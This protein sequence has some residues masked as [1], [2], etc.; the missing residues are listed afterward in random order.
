MSLS[1]GGIGAARNLAA[2]R[3]LAITHVV[4]ASPIVPCFHAGCLRYRTVAVFDDAGEDI[5]QFFDATNRWIDKVQNST[6]CSLEIKLLSKN[7]YK[8]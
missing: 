5:A 1:A 3:G 6:N 4:N 7:I 8:M 2:L